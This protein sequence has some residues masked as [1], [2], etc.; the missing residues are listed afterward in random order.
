MEY[1]LKHDPQGGLMQVTTPEGY[2]HRF[3]SV[4]LLGMKVIKYSPPWLSD[5]NTSYTFCIDTNDEIIHKV[6]PSQAFQSP[7]KIIEPKNSFHDAADE[8]SIESNGVATLIRDEKSMIYLCEK[9]KN[10]RLSSKTLILHGKVACHQTFSYVLN[11]KLKKHSINAFHK[12]YE[13]DLNGRLA[14]M[15]SNDLAMK[16]IY[17]LNANIVQIDYDTNNKMT[18]YVRS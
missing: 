4:P 15:S 3:K 2:H 11:S 13:Y 8:F 7:Q 17:D 10:G 12:L 14:S 9:D 1:S 6:Y 16:V 5:S 18:K